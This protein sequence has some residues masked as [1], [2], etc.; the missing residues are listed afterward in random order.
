MTFKKRDGAIA[1]GALGFVFA[2]ALALGLTQMAFLPY[3]IVGAFATLAL[4]FV[5]Y[6]LSP[7][8]KDTPKPSLKS[9]KL[10][11]AA[12]YFCSGKN[13]RKL[14]HRFFGV[15]LLL[16]FFIRFLSKH[17]YLEGVASLA[18]G[19]MTPFEVAFAAIGNCWWVG[20][21]VDVVIMEFLDSD[22][23]RGVAKWVVTPI[24]VLLTVGLP[25]VIEG[26]TGPLS[27]GSFSLSAL[28]MVLEYGIMAALVLEKWVLDP[29]IKSNRS[30][31]YGVL[32]A[33]ILLV[34]VTVND[35]LPQNLFGAYVLDLPLAKNFNF[36]H[37]LFIYG[38]FLLPLFYFFLLFP[39]DLAHRRAFLFF[40][41]QV[42]LISYASVSRIEVWQH[43]YS[44]PLHLCNTAMY[45]MPLTLVF[46]SHKLFYFTMFVNVIGAFLALM[47]PNYSSD[48]PVMGAAVVQFYINHLYAFFLP[49]LI[50]ELGIF[51][52]PKWKY[53]G[54][55]MVGFTLYFVA[56]AFLNIYYTGMKDFYHISAPD[57]FFINSDFIAKKVG[58][59]GEDLW[60]LSLT[61][62][63]QG[64]SFSFHL[65]YLISYYLVYVGFALL[66]WYLYE[67]LFKATD[68]LILLH[69]RQRGYRVQRFEFGKTQD[70]RK[71]KTMEIEKPEEHAPRIAIAHLTKKY[72]TSKEAAVEDFSLDITGGK[73]YGFLGKNGAGKSTI[74]K[75]IVGMHGF[76][77]GS[78]AVCGYDVMQEPVQA[79]SQI[80]FVPDNYAL[81]ENLT[82]RQYLNYI[83]DL[84]EVSASE[85]ED[86]LSRLLKRMEMGDYYDSQMK[87]YSHGMKQKITIM[88]ALIHDPKVWILDE[89]M[90]GVDPN[91]I[92]EIKECMRE[93][94]QRGNLVFFSSHLIDVVKNL[95]D[96]II[97]IKRGK[98]VFRAPMREL[99]ERGLD[100]ETLFLEKTADTEE[101][102][103]QLLKDERKN[104]VG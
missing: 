55:S 10:Q 50:M 87:T 9:K 29:S 100:L 76:N 44:M 67:L 18:S 47:M 74:I 45:I 38:A 53:F 61:A 57:Y 14:L 101:E 15:A 92:F 33:W 7:R 23:Y 66:M 35:Y 19:F 90:T 32:V 21:L 103:A 24:L 86:R 58:G 40:I 8:L 37:R 2:L 27:S 16:L 20:A 49:V 42:A 31:R 69:E 41:A 30:L 62:N 71:E 3:E 96:E 72:G 94:A 91:S 99:S 11:A 68:T 5:L 17:D 98:L 95:C 46:R 12:D 89:P 6:F 73:I 36:T 13:K 60:N 104:P 52:R 85:R 25:W 75:A 4:F 1:G 65:P 54:Y 59:W 34:L 26:V 80:G 84:Y 64:Y 63:I 102:A 93:H 82:G 48:W 88:G 81:Y 79:K 51:E 28:L 97:I 83:A 56:V 70:N 77:S 22:V 43:F 39:L 78:I